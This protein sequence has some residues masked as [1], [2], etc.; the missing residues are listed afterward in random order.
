MLILS[1]TWLKANVSDSEI[2]IPGYTLSRNDRDSRIGGG[3]LA[4]NRDGL[5]Y[6]CAL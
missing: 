6:L 5:P 2:C 3:T 1:K 4:Y